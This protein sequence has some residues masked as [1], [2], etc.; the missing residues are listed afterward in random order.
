MYFILLYF[1]HDYVGEYPWNRMH[2]I[3]YNC[4]QT[5]HDKK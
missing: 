2:L 1:P 4:P 5:V 3:I